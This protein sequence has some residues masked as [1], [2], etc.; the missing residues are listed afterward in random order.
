MVDLFGDGW[1]SHGE[2]TS[3]F[4]GIVDA[5]DE[6]VSRARVTANETAAAGTR[7]TLDVWCEN[8]DGTP[9]VVGTATGRL[10]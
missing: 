3:K 6:V 4:I 7:I 2:L 5:G 9:V 10:D 1:L 8:W